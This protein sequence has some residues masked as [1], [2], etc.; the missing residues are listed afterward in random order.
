MK[1][2]SIVFVLYFCAMAL[3]HGDDATP[4]DLPIFLPSQS[5][6]CLPYADFIH[7]DNFTF[8]KETPNC[9]SHTKEFV[10]EGELDQEKGNASV[11]TREE[12]ED[13]GSTFEKEVHFAKAADAGATFYHTT[14]QYTPKFEIAE[15]VYIF[16][17]N[18]TSE[19]FFADG[20]FDPTIGMI[21]KPEKEGSSLGDEGILFETES[22]VIGRFVYEPPT[23]LTGAYYGLQI[24][25]KLGRLFDSRSKN[26]HGGE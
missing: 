4:V 18:G 5:N 6:P 22:G 20:A 19:Y 8:T 9:F 17:P 12:A 21:D 26:S 11:L 3:A 25:G 23:E 7:R 16:Y 13:L 1:I 15:A 24:N 2:S 14:L 10:D